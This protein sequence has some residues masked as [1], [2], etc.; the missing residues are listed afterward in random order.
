MLDRRNFL[1]LAVAVAAAV[2]VNVTTGANCGQDDSLSIVFSD[3][4]VC[5]EDARATKFTP[6]RLA[7]FVD[8]ARGATCTFLYDRQGM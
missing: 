4:H 7:A 8:E 2:C 1:E 5:G 6:R 3:A